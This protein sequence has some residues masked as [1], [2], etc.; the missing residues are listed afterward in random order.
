MVGKQLFCWV[1]DVQSQGNVPETGQCK[2]NH[3]DRARAGG[4]DYELPDCVSQ[5]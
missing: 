3:P 1:R 4:S 5:P 2:L